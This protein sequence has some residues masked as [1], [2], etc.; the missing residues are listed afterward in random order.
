MEVLRGLGGVWGVR[1]GE[2]GDWVAGAGHGGG[3][4]E[5]VEIVVDKVGGVCEVD[6]VAGV[7]VAVVG[8]IGGNPVLEHGGGDECCVVL[9]EHCLDL[10]IEGL[11]V[12]WCVLSWTL[13]PGLA[14]SSMRCW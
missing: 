8:W 12:A 6:G 11:E 10:G 3:E 9:F 7:V 4:V 1:W 13:M 5:M 2:D 14:V